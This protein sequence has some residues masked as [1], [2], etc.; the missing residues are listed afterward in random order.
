MYMY[1]VFV[2]FSYQMFYTRIC[3]LFFFNLAIKCVNSPCVHGTCQDTIT[4]FTCNCDPKFSGMTCNTRKI[5]YSW[6][7]QIGIIFSLWSF[8]L[9]SCTNFN[10]KCNKKL[11]RL[12]CDSHKISFVFITQIIRCKSYLTW[13]K[14]IWFVNFNE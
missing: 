4:G 12:I 13:K 10:L 6:L 9:R 8:Y 3:S 2:Q 14:L 7:M 11:C 1:S 5:I